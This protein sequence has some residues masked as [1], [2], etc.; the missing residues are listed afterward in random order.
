MNYDETIVYLYSRGLFAIK[1]GL[2]NITELMEKLGNP[3]RK[4]KSIHIAGTNGKGSV[5]AFLSSILQKQGYKVGVYTSPHL[6][7]FRER[8]RINN[9]KIS[10]NKVVSLVERIKPLV[11][12]HT[13]FEIVTA[14][15]FLYFKEQKVDFA[16]V[17]VGMGGRLD[18]TNVIKPEVAVITSISKEHT[19]HLGKTIE[20]ITYEKA[21]IIKKG[22]DVVASVH[23]DG[24]KQ[25]KHVCHIK[26]CGLNL[27]E[28]VK[29]ESNLKGRFQYENL[30]IALKVI[31]L[32]REKG[33]EISEES[34]K[35]GIKD[36]RWPGRFDF[37]FENVIFDCAHNPD[38]AETLVNEINNL[39]YDRLYVILG[40]M[41][42]KDI[43]GICRPLERIADEIIVTK[44]E[45]TRAAEPEEIKNFI[46]KEVRI[47]RNVKEAL[48]YAM[49]KAKKKDLVVLTGSIFTVGEGF[50]AI[51]KD[52][53]G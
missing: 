15:A 34:V 2:N 28:P 23:N 42:D 35:A 26:D 31:E 41:K 12:T 8:I 33:Y 6:V 27:V 44:P 36:V 24:L 20:K 48:D 21:G 3:Q 49:G 13:Y 43:E 22:V 52:P 32:L 19:K 50:S 37:V 46:K 1:L 16:L 14:M 39:S 47:I 5:C 4:F 18:A 17:E 11:D 7:D 10:K 25:I 40:I 45:I 29:V 30:G 9:K 38:G 53:F 51:K